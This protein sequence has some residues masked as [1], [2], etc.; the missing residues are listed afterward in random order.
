[1]LIIARIVVCLFCFEMGGVFRWHAT[2][3]I[4]HGLYKQRLS[5]KHPLSLLKMQWSSCAMNVTCFIFQFTDILKKYF[6]EIQ[7]TSK[8]YKSKKMF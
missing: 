3:R 6:T 8:F 5:S 4:W 7:Q 2:T 1:M